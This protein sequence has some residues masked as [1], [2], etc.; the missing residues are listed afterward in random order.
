[1]ND[2]LG[3]GVEGVTKPFCLKNVFSN[4]GIKERKKFCFAARKGF[5]RY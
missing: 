3:E 4:F 5:K 1:M 2:I